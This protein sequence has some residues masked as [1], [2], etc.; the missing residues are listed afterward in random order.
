MDGQLLTAEGLRFVHGLRSRGER[1]AVVGPDGSRL[2]YRDLAARV[3][4]TAARLG[5]VR[6][7]VLVAAS[8]DLDT[9]VTYL[10]GLHGG[11]AVLLA[12]GENQHHLGTL[13]DRYDPD[14]VAAPGPQ[15][16][17]VRERRAG[18]AHV[19][20]PDLA[21]LL[22]TSGSTGSPKLVRLSTANLQSNADAIAT[23]LD[24]HDTDRA[25]LSL[26][27]H[28][29][30]GLS[31]VNS[32]L[33][34]GAAILLNPHSVAEPEFW[35]F[36]RQHEGTSLHGV[37]YTFDLL[38]RVGFDRMTLPSLRY[39]T[40][41]GGKLAPERV[42][43]YAELGERR[44]WRFFVMYGQTEA[45]ARMAY[46]PPELATSHPA[47]IG[48][49]VPGG[50]F[51]LAPSDRPDEG[52]LIYHGPNVML[53]YAEDPADLARGRTT[54]ALSTGDLARRTPDGLYEVIGRRSRIVKLYG[55]RVDLDRTEDLLRERGYQAACGGTDET[56]IVAV[57]AGQDT[58]AIRDLVA[59]HLRLPVHSL[60]VR[61]FD[62]IPRLGN[63]K[64]DYPQLVETLHADQAD[65]RER[66]P[67]SV[68]AVFTAAFPGT[69]ITDDDTF[70]GLGGDSLSYIPT[71]LALE[72][73]LGDLP[74]GWPTTSVGTLSARQPR[75]RRLTPIDT[76]ILL[77]AA[78]ITLVVGTHIGAFHLRGGAH[79]LLAVAGWTFARFLLSGQPTSGARIARSAARIAAPAVL[80]LLWRT[81]ASDDV[82]LSNVLLINNYV[83]GGAT[84]YWFIE[85]LVQTLLL[86]AVLFTIPAVRRFEQRH[87][88][89]AAAAILGVTLLARLFTDDA[90]G[91]PE[92]AFTTHGA[93]WFFALG[94]LAQR[95]S[96]SGRKLTVLAVMTLLVPGYFPEPGR[97]LIVFGG[98][99]LLIF[100]PSIRLPRLAAR[101]T[102]L[103]AASSLYIYLT[104]YA[105]FPALLPHF[106]LPV[107]L[108][109]CLGS[110]IVA[111]I[112][113]QRM[114]GACARIL[115]WRAAPTRLSDVRVDL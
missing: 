85:V 22:S 4:A 61:E 10:A 47:A 25:V 62:E 43:A 100:L 109:A 40:Q 18:S 51:D 24:I 48:I 111:W 74:P 13:I 80:W 54:T 64:V 82:R 104:H 12:D 56:L 73:V 89:G 60:Q 1:T 77:R 98:L 110:G 101:A 38:D 65:S 96:T 23:Y 9:L 46:L 75:R 112:L 49:P 35:T 41:A 107:V 78:S 55:H 97:N 16:W 57:L 71:A 88:F 90:H 102:S 52:E 32:N 15:G 106:A 95:A 45:T 26:P 94:W 92:S 5:T 53:G 20:H 7:L 50:S 19:L 87:R 86:L 27:M 58:T 44:G 37:P 115:A 103:L 30:Y 108:A 93:A 34:R 42:R 17:S 21:L 81:Q 76:E 72:R 33:A 28:Y 84:G 36:F 29:C 2:S 14:V 66:T 79:L 59:D 69:R 3:A 11:H 70:V 31:V 6:R 8:S 114:G 105:V 39:V 63:G 91:F 83:R 99:A 67:R 113:V 68:R